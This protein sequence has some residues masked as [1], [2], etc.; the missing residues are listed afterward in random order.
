[1]LKIVLS[2]I[3]TFKRYCKANLVCLLSFWWWQFFFYYFAICLCQIKTLLLKIKKMFKIIGFSRFFLWFLFKI[4]GF[5]EISQS[6][7]FLA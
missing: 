5:F 7:A 4:P 3:T 6:T 2:I 1:M